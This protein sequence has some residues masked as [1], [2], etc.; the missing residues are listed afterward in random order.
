MNPMI[1]RDYFKRLAPIDYSTNFDNLTTSGYHIY[2]AY[3]GSGGSNRPSD[4]LFMG[5]LFVLNMPTWGNVMQIMFP[6]SPTVGIRYRLKADGVWKPWRGSPTADIQT[7][8][9]TSNNF[10]IETQRLQK[11][12]NLVSFYLAM[13][14]KTAI[15]NG[16]T[17]EWATFPTGFRAAQYTLFTVPTGN[18]SSTNLRNQTLVVAVGTTG[19]LNGEKTFAVGDKIQ[20]SGMFFTN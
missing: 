10:T 20:I 16:W 4:E 2:N 19:N 11:T 3:S 14:C 12:G 1:K 7:G 8:T 13:T 18:Q 17:Q 5:T 15:T 6:N 9:I